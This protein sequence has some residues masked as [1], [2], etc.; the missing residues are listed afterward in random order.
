MSDRAYAKVQAQQKTSI[1]SSPK[2]SLLQRTCA[3]GQHTIAGGECEACRQKREGAMHRAAVSS[4]PVNAVPPVVHGVLSSSGQPLDAGTRTFMEPRFGHDFSQVRVHTGAEANAAAKAVNALAYTIGPD[5]VFGTEQYAPATA[6]GRRLLAH[7]LTHT[8]QQGFQKG[9]FPVS[10]DVASPESREEQEADA[11][12]RS[13]GKGHDFTARIGTPLQVARKTSIDQNKERIAAIRQEARN[14]DAEALARMFEDT[15]IVDDGTVQGRLRAILN[16]TENSFIPGLQ[17]GIEFS[18]EGFKG[19]RSPGGAGFRD[20]HPSSRNQVGHFL[21]AVG[22]SFNPAKVEEIFMGRRL[23]D[24]LE[25]P[26]SMSKEEVALRLIIGHE[27][28]PDP[29]IKDAMIG[30]AIGGVIGGIIGPP[31]SGPTSA[32]LDAARA[33]L[34]GFKRQFKQ[35]TDQD[36]LAFRQANV[37]LGTALTMDMS[38]AETALKPIKDKINPKLRGNSV[39]DLRLSLAGWNLGQLISAGKFATGGDVAKWV[40]LNLK[41]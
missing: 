21:T 39:Q 35:A 13:I 10:V 15:Y 34:D 9:H 4:A 26:N 14:N 7:E 3:C 6:A 25:A 36:V 24:W 20:P 22:L 41:Q 28:A 19:D 40:R 17:T 37:A 5:I 32:A 1:G 31:G 2:S 23:R 12:A 33:M 29:S 8:I 18:D 16:A 27:L 30:A 11:A 38:A